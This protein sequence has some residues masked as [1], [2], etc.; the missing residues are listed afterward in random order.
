MSFAFLYE[1]GFYVITALPVALAMQAAATWIMRPK[2]RELLTLVDRVISDPNCTKADKAWVV[3]ELGTATDRWLLCLMALLSPFIFVGAMIAAGWDAFS[4]TDEDNEARIARHEREY[5]RVN[6]S[7]VW[8]EFD[9]DPAQGHFWK[10]EKH[11]K[12]NDLAHEIEA[13]S[14][15]I[16]MALL[17]VWIAAGLPLALAGYGLARFFRQSVG[18]PLGRTREGISLLFAKLRLAVHALT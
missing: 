12:I 11:K 2:R 4:H 16:P 18:A 3:I 8:D 7:I 9:I 14:N 6:A 5:A 17:F 15:P 13:G 10:S 1:P